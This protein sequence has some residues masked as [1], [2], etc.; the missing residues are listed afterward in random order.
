MSFII[1]DVTKKFGSVKALKGVS[2]E[3]KKGEVIG[4]LGPNGAGK[5]T[6]MKILTGYYTKWEGDIHFFGQDLRTE[7]RDIQKK[8]GYLPENNPLYSEMHVIEY[9]KFSAGLYH[10]SKPQLT[11]IIQKTGLENHVQN[12]HNCQKSQII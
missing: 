10:I 11:E 7:L 2:M 12:N 5:S 4:L 8:T 3:L 1:T 9:L 6:L